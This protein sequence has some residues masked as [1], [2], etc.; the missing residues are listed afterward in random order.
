M[1]LGLVSTI[2]IGVVMA[3]ICIQTRQEAWSY[4]DAVAGALFL[5]SGVVFPLLVLPG[6]LQAIGLLSPL[7]WWIEGVRY[8]LFPGGLSSLGGVGSFFASV[9]SHTAPTSVEIAIAL[10][11]T[12][13]VATLGS[14]AA[15]RV[16]DR[17]AKDRGLL[18]L[19]TGS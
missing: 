7:G 16:S 3:A 2:A 19:T 1:A 9:T 14:V 13:T 8:A 17:R 12:G 18:D 4:P 15:F 6:P 10:L 5:V 11:A